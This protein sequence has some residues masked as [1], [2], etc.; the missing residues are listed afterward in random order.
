MI[1]DKVTVKV[2]GRTEGVLPPYNE[3]AFVVEL[4]VDHPLVH[5][6]IEYHLQQVRVA[7]LKDPT[8]IALF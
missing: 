3:H 7:L 4:P 2:E 5:E 1:L 6:I 8:Q